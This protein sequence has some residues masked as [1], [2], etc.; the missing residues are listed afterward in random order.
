[1]TDST[2]AVA[3]SREAKLYGIKTGTKI[4][5]AKRMCPNLHCVLA[6]HNMYV[7]YHHM[8]MDE[9][10]NHIPI[11]KTYSIDEA[12][13]KLCDNETSREVATDIALRIKQGLRDNVGAFVKCS[14]GIAPNT[15]LA[16]IATIL[17]KRDGLVIFEPNNYKSALFTLKL[18]DLTGVGKNIERR[19]NR[20]GIHTIEQLWNISP[21]HARRIWGNVGGEQFWY[22]LHGYDIPETITQ[23][24]VVGHSRVLDPD[25]RKS[26]KAF[27]ITRELTVKAAA[28]LRRY[29]LY[30]RKFHLSVRTCDERRWSYESTFAPTQDNFT[31]IRTLERL[32]SAMVR[33][34]PHARLLKVS[35]TL[36]D[37]YEREDITLDLF[38]RENEKTPKNQA[39]SETIDTINARYGKKAVSIGTCVR[40]KAGHVGTKIAFSRIPDKEEFYE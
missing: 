27:D 2:C 38:E 16:K 5:D 18:S 40:T 8:I 22:R 12:A 32:W 9:V 4:Y 29:N 23:K 15:F 13:C 37:L 31:F 25:H 35:I 10:E 1:M 39:L 34:L 3:A 17:D 21:K 11:S 14:I 24:R 20:A 19:L 7:K 36:H 26:D 28:R 6:R 33:D 30:A